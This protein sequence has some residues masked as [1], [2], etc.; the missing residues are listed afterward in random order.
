MYYGRTASYGLDHTPDRFLDPTLRVQ[1]PIK[2]LLLTG[3][4]VLCDGV[5]PQPLTGLMTCAKVLGVSSADFWFLMGECG[6][7]VAWR[8]LTDRTH[9]L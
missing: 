7:S 2:G 9:R 8:M 3:Q 6:L 5:F 4:D 1:T